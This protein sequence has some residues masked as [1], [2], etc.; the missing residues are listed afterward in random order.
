MSDNNQERWILV[1][2][3][4]I[5]ERNLS[6]ALTLSSSGRARNLYIGLSSIRRGLYIN[7]RVSPSCFEQGERTA[8]MAVRERIYGFLVEPEAASWIM[9]TMEKEKLRAATRLIA[10]SLVE[11]LLVLVASI[12][13]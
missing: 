5:L 9:L 4:L 6:L 1:L 12:S 7:T 11:S 2:H 3:L 8:D 10:I 13:C